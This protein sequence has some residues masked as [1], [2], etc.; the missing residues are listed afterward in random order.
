M[1]LR[2]MDGDKEM[3]IIQV[4]YVLTVARYLNISRAAQS[5]FISQ[6]ALSS[7][8]GKLEGEL[9]YPLFVRE[10]QGVQLTEEGRIFCENAQPVADAWSRLKTLTGPDR[11]QPL[12]HVRIG[13]DVRAIANDALNLT[14]AFFRAGS[15][16]QGDLQY[17][18]AP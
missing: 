9:G 15:G 13:L 11:R 17:G 14:A 2:I 10:A 16:E 8:I 7:Q 6:P 12:S 18:P 4:Q 5:L 1:K 3:T